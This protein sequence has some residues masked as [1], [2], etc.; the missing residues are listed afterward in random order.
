VGRDYLYAPAQ[1]ELHMSA[2]LKSVK[3]R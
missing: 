3:G 1:A 2:F